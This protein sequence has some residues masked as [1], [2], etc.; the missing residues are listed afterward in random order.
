[1][2][3]LL[4][5]LREVA[6][7]PQAVRVDLVRLAKQRDGAGAVAR[8]PHVLGPREEVLRVGL[9]IGTRHGG[10][11]ER[12]ETEGGGY[13]DA[14]KHAGKTHDHEIINTGWDSRDTLEDL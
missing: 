11:T 8:G 12:C 13:A 14:A 2:A 9:G 4:L 6:H 5:A 7:A 1:M 3:E 10:S